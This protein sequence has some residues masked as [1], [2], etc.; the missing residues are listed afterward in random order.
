ML[1]IA[2]STTYSLSVLEVA[3]KNFNTQVEQAIACEALHQQY[4][5]LVAGS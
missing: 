1:R 2:D 3:T 4:E 5:A